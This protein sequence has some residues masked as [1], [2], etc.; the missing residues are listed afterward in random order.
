MLYTRVRVDFVKSFETKRS[1]GIVRHLHDC[2]QKHRRIEYRGIGYLV[3]YSTQLH[4]QQLYREIELMRR[5]SRSEKR[6]L[7]S[8]LSG[9]SP[10]GGCQSSANLS[11][12][13]HFRPIEGPPYM[14]LPSIGWI[15]ICG[16]AKGRLMGAATAAV[17]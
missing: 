7:L 4:R 16:Q 13:N 9:I 10:F 3:Y 5:R 17:E 12:G 1:Q 15:H 11:R 8:W 2:I 14:S 6:K